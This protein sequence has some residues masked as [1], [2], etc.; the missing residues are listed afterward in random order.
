MNEKKNV[1]AYKLSREG[2]KKKK[3]FQVGN[4][5]SAQHERFELPSAAG[6]YESLVRKLIGEIQFFFHPI[7]TFSRLFG[8]FLQEVNAVQL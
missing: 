5:D 6:G 2:L 7:S 1:R 3:V 8:I 4:L